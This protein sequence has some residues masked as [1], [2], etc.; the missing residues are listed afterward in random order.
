MRWKEE[1]EKMKS[2]YC[3]EYNLDLA[4][5]TIVNIAMVPVDRDIGKA[6]S[7]FKDSL[8]SAAR[9]RVRDQCTDP[10]FRGTDVSLQ[11]FGDGKWSLVMQLDARSGYLQHEV[12]EYCSDMNYMPRTEVGVKSFYVASFF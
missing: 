2:Q 11:E 12:N 8:S 5:E 9:F 3:T 6:G 4:D 1:L 7:A 10:L